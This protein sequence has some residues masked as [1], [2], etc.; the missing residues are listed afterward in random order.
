MFWTAPELI[1]SHGTQ[2]T[3][4]G[5]VYS[6]GIICAEIANRNPPYFERTDLSP[7]GVALHNK[8]QT[9]HYYYMLPL[10]K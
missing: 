5:D 8:F 7:K 1:G 6:Y 4:K 9:I 3:K 10:P 2:G